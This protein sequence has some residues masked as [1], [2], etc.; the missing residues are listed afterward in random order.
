MRIRTA[1]EGDIPQIEALYQQLF[2]D[3]ARLQPQYLR[4]ANQSRGFLERII[5]SSGSDILL[6]EEGTEAV[7]FLLL[8]AQETPPYAC[9]L[10]HQY[11][12]VMDLV[13]KEEYR[14]QGIGTALLDYAEYWARNRNLD[15]LELNVLSQ[16]DGAAR[17]YEQKGYREC[18]RTM[19]RNIQ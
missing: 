4:P 9:F 18:L 13:V 7:G 19:R 16:N 6:A 8:Q 3:M 5:E 2:C 10:P 15:Y 14:G 1:A 12:Y 17:L 11:A